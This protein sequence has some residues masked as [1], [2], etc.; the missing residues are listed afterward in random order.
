MS[1]ES[2]LFDGVYWLVDWLVGW[3]AGVC[4]VVVQ[5]CWSTEGPGMAGVGYNPPIESMV[6]RS[7]VAMDKNAYKTSRQGRR[8]GALKEVIGFGKLTF[9]SKSD[10]E[11]KLVF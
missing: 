11:A 8:R 7:S 5:G 10:S 3:L 4:F 1:N 2:F 9:L 6:A